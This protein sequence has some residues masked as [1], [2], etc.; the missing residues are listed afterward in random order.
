MGLQAREEGVLKCCRGRDASRDR[1]SGELV[2]QVQRLGASVR[3]HQWLG[4]YP[5]T[6]VHVLSEAVHS[7]MP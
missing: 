5:D 6:C 2:G 7:S 4:V 3:V 1:M